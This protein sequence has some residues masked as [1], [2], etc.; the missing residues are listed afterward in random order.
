MHSYLS[1]L[2]DAQIFGT[3]SDWEKHVL[4]E[5]STFVK[6]LTIKDSEM[7]AQIAQ[8]FDEL[9]F[10]PLFFREHGRD[11]VAIEG[12]KAC[13]HYKTVEEAFVAQI[14]GKHSAS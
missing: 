13:T 14:L 8:R 12:V 3:R 7:K 4:G 6:P 11:F 10:I 9:G 2:V 5:T 1:Q